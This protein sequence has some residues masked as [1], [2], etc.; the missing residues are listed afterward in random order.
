MSAAAQPQTRGQAVPS[1]LLEHVRRLDVGLSDR[2]SA[3]DRL[4]QALGRELA[5][6]LLSALAGD[7]G[8][9]CVL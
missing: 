4:E 5:S 9:R 7:H 6:W 3:T 8:S 2:P 1:L